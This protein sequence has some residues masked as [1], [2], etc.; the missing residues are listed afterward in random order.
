M[1]RSLRILVSGRI[2]GAAHQGGASW[3]VL[4]YLL[5][6]E[7]LGHDVRFVEPIAWSPADPA[8]PQGDTPDSAYGHHVLAAS[9]MH[10][11]S[12]FL[13]VSGGTTCQTSVEEV[14]ELTRG[15]DVL[16]NLSGVLRDREM[17]EL[18]PIRVYV[19]LDPAFT[20]LWHEVESIDVGLAG[21]THYVT[22]GQ[23][24]G[25]PGCDIPKCGVEWIP[26]LP[27]VVLRCWPD[28]L[29]PS[30][31]AVTTVGNWRGYGPVMFR[32]TTYGQ[33]AHSFRQ[34]AKLPMMSSERF[35]VALAIDPAEHDDLA[36]LTQNGWNLVDPRVL[37][38]T[39]E[40]FADFVRA[41]KAELDVPKSGY[42]VSR[43]G[44]FSDRSACY[45][46]SGRPVVAQDTGFGSVVPTGVGLMAF[47]ILDEAIDAIDRMSSEYPRHV[48]AARQIA[49][50]H[51][52]ARIVLRSLLDRIGA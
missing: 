30:D 5:G 7:E 23:R 41:S 4:Q 25:Q 40:A 46:A 24:I 52:D 38:G 18:I 32:N 15:C 8:G 10:G 9:G 36:M 35:S 37:A 17:T 22:V 49:E 48:R 20:Q 45:L 29:A 44:W 26:S 47:D 34:I 28:S 3:A 50:E 11:R 14:V 51:F 43:S 6:F 31:G 13:D 12:L 39:P 19:D 16:I 1:S 21:H 27:P 33:R 42:V 2:A